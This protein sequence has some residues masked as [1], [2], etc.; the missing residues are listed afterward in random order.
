MLPPMSR[1]A[2]VDRWLETQTQREA[3]QCVRDVVLGADPRISEDVKDGT[4]RFGYLGDVASFVE[5]DAPGVTIRFSDGARLAGAF[6][7]L[8]GAGDDRFLRFSDLADVRARANELRGVAVACCRLRSGGTEIP[9]SVRSL[10]R[11]G[12]KKA[13]APK[14]KA[15]APKKKAAAP[16]KK[17][18]APKKKPAAPKKKPAAPKKKPAAPK[19][20]PAAP[21]KKAPATKSPAPKTKAKSKKR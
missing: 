10:P 3:L 17:A 7:H 16:K 8:E 18:A 12:K 20:K 1:N 14:K 21:K 13:A 19:K 5:L 9:P 15:A 2:E 4:I 6:P 11:G